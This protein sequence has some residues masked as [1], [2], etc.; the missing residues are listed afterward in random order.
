[1]LEVDAHLD[2]IRI[3]YFTYFLL[4]LILYAHGVGLLLGVVLYAH[5][6]VC[7]VASQ[8]IAMVLVT[9]DGYAIDIDANDSA[10]DMIADVV[11]TRPTFYGLMWSLYR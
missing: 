8:V 11:R 3:A 1:M 5:N 10:V 2:W 7:I 4:T 6:E 9:V